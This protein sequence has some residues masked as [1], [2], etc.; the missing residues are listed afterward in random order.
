MLNSTKIKAH[1]NCQCAEVRA[2]HGARTCQC[3]GSFL[4]CEQFKVNFLSRV[5]IDKIGASTYLFELMQNLIQLV[6]LHTKHI[7]AAIALFVS[8]LGSAYGADS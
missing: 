3:S 4:A 5:G 2:R 6:T 1:G 8:L 7:G